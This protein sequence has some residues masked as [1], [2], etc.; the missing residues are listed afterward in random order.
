MNHQPCDTTNCHQPAVAFV[1]D[2][3]VCSEHAPVDVEVHS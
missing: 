2:V 1:D 3:F